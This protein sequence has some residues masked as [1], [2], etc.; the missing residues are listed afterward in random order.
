LEELGNEYQETE[1][2]LPEEEI[3]VNTNSI[4]RSVDEELYTGKFT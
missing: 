4:L 3:I 2:H 1:Q